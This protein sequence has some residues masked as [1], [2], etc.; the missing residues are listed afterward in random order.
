V[1]LENAWHHEL[2]SQASGDH[3]DAGPGESCELSVG[4]REQRLG[5]WGSTAY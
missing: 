2:A 4:W 1:Q 5:H 3:H